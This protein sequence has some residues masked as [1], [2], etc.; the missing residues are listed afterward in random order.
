MGISAVE[1]QPREKLVVDAMHQVRQVL[2]EAAL[3]H[4]CT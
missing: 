3:V 4:G 1:A 2:I